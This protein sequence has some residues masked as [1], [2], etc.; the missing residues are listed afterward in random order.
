MSGAKPPFDAEAIMDSMAPFLGLTVEEEYRSGVVQHLNAA[1]I[2]AQSVLAVEL[3][4]TA[5]PAP[6]YRP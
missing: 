1:W 2:I 3:E 6:V 5:E 4:D